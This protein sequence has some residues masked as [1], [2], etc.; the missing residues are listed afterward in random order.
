MAS[1]LRKREA[2]RFPVIEAL[3]Q[4]ENLRKEKMCSY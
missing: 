1:P 3:S 2:M 4:E